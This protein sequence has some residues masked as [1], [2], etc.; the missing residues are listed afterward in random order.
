MRT[1]EG[2]QASRPNIRTKA[3]KRHIAAQGF[4]D[5]RYV[6]DDLL[7]LIQQRVKAHTLSGEPY[8]DAEQAAAELARHTLPAFFLDFETISFAVPIWKGTPPYQPLTLQFSVHRLS[9]SGELEHRDFLD[10]SGE[11]PRE[12]LTAA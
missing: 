7:N 1:L 4:T 6:R 8:F 12:A 9:E 5:L 10:L 2:P 3:L 11:D